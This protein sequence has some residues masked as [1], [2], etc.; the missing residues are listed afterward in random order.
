MDSTVKDGRHALYRVALDG[1]MKRELVLARPDVDIDG[2]VRVGRQQ[3][4][5]R[6]ELR[7][8]TPP[9]R[10]LRSR[11]EAPAAPSLEKA[12]PKGP[13]VSFVDASAD[14]SKL[15]LY[16][17]SDTDPGRY[18]L[19]DKTTRQLG[20]VIGRP[21]GTGAAA[22]RHDVRRSPIRPPTARRIPGYLTLPPGSNGKNLP[23]IVMPHGGPGARDEWGF[24]WLVAVLRRARLC[25]ASAQFPRLD[26]LWR[27]M[28]PE[29]RLPIVA[30]RDRRRQRR[31]AAGW[32]GQGIAAPGKLAIVGWSY[33]GY[34][35]LQSAVLDPE[36]FK[37]IVAIAPVTDLD[38]LREESRD[39]T[40]FAMVDALHRARPAHCARDRRRATRRRSRRRC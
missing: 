11:T 22:A 2:L 25:R 6:R 1:S 17:G 21:V 28:V 8:R 23:A 27:R 31:R 36:L 15:L 35:A 7:H 5:G 12:V 24:D 16:V 38:M 32:S 9:D 26:R 34:A 37:A 33:G 4:R 19:Y 18:Y 39:Y 30:N 14:E 10:I 40:N 20:E 3:P 13:L 29:E